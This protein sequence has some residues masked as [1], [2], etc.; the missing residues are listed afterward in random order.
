MFAAKAAEPP[1]KL[2]IN[3]TTRFARPGPWVAAHGWR[4]GDR[5]ETPSPPRGSVGSGAGFD[6]GRISMHAA[7]RGAGHAVNIPFRAVI[8]ASGI[9]GSGRSKT[10][11]DAAT[12][13]APAKPKPQPPF[14]AN[15]PASPK[16]QETPLGTSLYIAQMEG[17]PGMKD[18]KGIA[19]SV[20]ATFAYAPTTTRGGVTLGA[21]DFG[22]TEGSLKHFSNVTITP[23]AGKFT[24][25]ADLKQT[26]NWD[27]RA[28]MGPDNQ[29]NIMSETDAA[30]N[31]ANFAQA[32]ADLTP[33]VTDLKGR[34]PRT[35]FWSKDLTETH[36]QFH[37][38]DYVDIARTGATDAQA[39]LA[40]QNAAHKEDVPA[41]LDTAWHD[42]IFQVWD[43]F[44]NPPAV[45]E[46]AYADG[47]PSYKARADAITAKGSKGAHGGYPAP[48]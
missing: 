45:E 31:S 6:F 46:R 35:K 13:E 11:H 47:A 1:Q 4:S 33:N 40:T 12:E 27:T 38:K 17:P 48:P 5:D 23:G 25:T 44:T 2:P 42:K 9:W 41:L 3:S 18:T 22:A 34:P 16:S 37:A 30:L 43:A 15:A 36:E 26:V 19:D 24:V 20:G 29:V 39:W 21:G 10:V 14:A 28:T 7:G 32:A 8:P